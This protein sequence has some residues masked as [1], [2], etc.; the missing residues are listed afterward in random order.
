MKRYLIS[1][2]RNKINIRDRKTEQELSLS[3]I[4]EKIAD[5][6]IEAI[7]SVNYSIPTRNQKNS[8][9]NINYETPNKTKPTPWGE[10]QPSEIKWVTSWYNPNKKEK[11]NN[12]SKLSNKLNKLLEI[13]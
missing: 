1:Y 13:Q 9:E 7:K 3:H 10:I 2:S 6:Y 4:D 5:I 12:Q 8:Y 11:Q